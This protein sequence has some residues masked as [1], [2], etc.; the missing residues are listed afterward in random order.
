MNMPI[1]KV[2]KNRNVTSDNVGK[3]DDSE[4]NHPSMTFS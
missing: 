4:E 3:I 2:C 1:Q